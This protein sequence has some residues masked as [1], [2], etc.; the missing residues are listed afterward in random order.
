MGGLARLATSGE[1]TNAVPGVGETLLDQ[2]NREAA[3]SSRFRY[4]PS[5][6]TPSVA[7]PVLFPP[8]GQADNAALESRSD[9]L[10]FTGP[11]LTQS[12]DVVGTPRAEIVVTADTPYA[13][14]FVRVCDVDPRGTSRNV[15]DGIL[16]LDGR[17]GATPTPI[18]LAL[19]PTAYRFGT[20]HRIRVLIAGGAL[21]AIRAQSR[22]WRGV[23]HRHG[24]AGK[25]G[26]GAARRD[27]REPSDPAGA[28]TGIRRVTPSFSAAP[29]GGRWTDRALGGPS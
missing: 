20:G 5:D 6:P 18:D 29:D 9:V 26:S 10:V 28:A 2:P 8:S 19:Y 3:S 21:P 4:D 16:R 24:D 11:A 15:I 27:A 13:D 12:I 14:L 1:G 7:G 23:E 22:Y 25:H 17:I